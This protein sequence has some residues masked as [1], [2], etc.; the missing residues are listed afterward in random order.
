MRLLRALV[1]WLFVPLMV[2]VILLWLFEDWLRG[3]E[4]GG[5]D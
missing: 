3:R 2:L 5:W 4:I 1:E